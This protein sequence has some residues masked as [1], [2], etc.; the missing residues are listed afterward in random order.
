MELTEIYP[1]NLAKAVLG[2][3]PDARA[4]YIPGISA[5]LGMLTE[6]EEK[7][8]RLRFKDK[9]TLEQAGKEC[10]V[11][12]ERVRQIEAKAIRKL[13]HPSRANMIKAVSLA[14][15]Q[16]RAKD[17]YKLQNDYA[18]LKKAF[19]SL[20]AQKADPEIIAPMV[21]QAKLLETPLEALDLS[22][23]AYNCLKR[24][25]KNKLGDIV[26]MYEHE[27]LAIRNMGKK[28]T[29][30]VKDMLERYGLKLK[31]PDITPAQEDEG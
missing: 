4:I 16:E 10:G 27:L 21:E 20:T 22:V 7:V 2:D 25:G 6:R 3:D 29:F 1:I 5:A 26:D 28:A 8:L 30:D 13:R 24:S 17:Y 31:N 15:V 18:W 12:R 9:M 11:T 23:R 14:E 19:E